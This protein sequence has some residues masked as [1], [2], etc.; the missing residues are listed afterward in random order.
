M[1]EENCLHLNKTQQGQL[2]DILLKYNKLFDGVL[3]EYPG[4]PMH[5]GLQPNASPVYR[6]PCPIPHVHL[7]TFKKELD[8]LV[9]IGV[10]SPFRDTEWGLPTL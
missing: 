10:L 7:A 1:I 9:A 4:Q 6:R 2:K 5:I 3:K 8:H